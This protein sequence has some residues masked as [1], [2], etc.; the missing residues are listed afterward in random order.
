MKEEVPIVACT[1]GQEGWGRFIPVFTDSLSYT[2]PSETLN[3]G[4]SV[5]AALLHAAK[6]QRLAHVGGGEVIDGGHAG[7]HAP[8]N[9]C[10]C[11]LTA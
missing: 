3:A 5:K 6:G 2:H 11:L 4:K 7:L 1:L 9:A 10:I 8:V